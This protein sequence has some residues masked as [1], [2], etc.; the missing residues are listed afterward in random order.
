MQTMIILP[1]SNP[2]PP[3]DQNKINS[4]LLHTWL[5]QQIWNS[6]VDLVSK[7]RNVWIIEEG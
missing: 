6:A 1:P 2:H 4:P 7:F 3:G 5:N